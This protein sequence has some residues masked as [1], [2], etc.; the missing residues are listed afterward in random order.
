M[1]YLVEITGLPPGASSP[2]IARYCSGES[3]VTLPGDT[4]PNTKYLPRIKDPGTYERHMWRYGTT[5]GRGE[6]SCGSVTLANADGELDFLQG[7]DL[8]GRALTILR[9]D[10]AAGR[11]S[12]TTCLAGTMDGCA[13]TWATVSIRIRDTAAIVADK[14]I[15]ADRFLGSNVLPAGVEGVPED[16][17]GKTKP[18]L[19]GE[20]ANFAPPL[21]NTSTNTFMISV[22]GIYQIVGVY[23]AGVALNPGVARANVAALQAA[24]PAAGAYD[25]SLGSASEGAYFRLGSSPGADIIT[26]TARA[27][28]P[29]GCT[30][31]QCVSTLLARAGAA[32]SGVAALDALQPAVVGYWVAVGGDIT[33]ATDAEL[34]TAGPQ[35]GPVLDALCASAGVSWA[36]ERDGT[37]RLRQLALPSGAPSVHFAPWQYLDT[38]TMLPTEDDGRGIPCYE[39]ELHYG[40]NF[41]T[42]TGTQVAGSVTA[43]RRAWLGLADRAARASNPA[44]WNPATQTGR[45]PSS[46]PATIKTYLRDEAAAL[47]EAT[48]LLGIYGAKLSYVSFQVASD[49]AIGVDIGTLLTLDTTRFDLSG[50]TLLVTG[51]L[52]AFATGSTT[53]YCWG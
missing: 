26:C 29:A 5:R 15:V 46:K 52:E 3:F 23:D 31:A 4:P 37:F 1:I 35:T 39:V 36:P 40:Q 9:G 44:I 38:L 50:K 14:L 2:E 12:F 21:V 6:V 53:L 10:P 51:F 20:A 18:F 7:W 22:V 17:K 32:A 33:A 43:A 28:A 30:V 8:D 49:Q 42:Q 19:V 41:T 25:Y 27:S 16:L 47:A 34:P 13:V 48:R 45:N 11:T 24:A